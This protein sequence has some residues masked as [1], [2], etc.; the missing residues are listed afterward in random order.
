[1]STKQKT[2]K[3]SRS[4]FAAGLKPLQ[5]LFLS[6][7]SEGKK[8]DKQKGQNHAPAVLRD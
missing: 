4:R 1:M 5:I 8:S 6:A 3:K 2:R 7:A